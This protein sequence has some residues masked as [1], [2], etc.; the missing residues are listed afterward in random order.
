MNSLNFPD[1]SMACTS[2]ST[3]KEGGYFTKLA[4]SVTTEP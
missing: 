1:N 4:F 2:V 3:C